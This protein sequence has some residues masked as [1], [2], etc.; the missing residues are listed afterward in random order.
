MTRLLRGEDASPPYAVAS[1]TGLGLQLA[2]LHP[3]AA[4]GKRLD[5]GLFAETI[6]RLRGTYDYIVIDTAS[7]LASAD[8]NSVS[9]CSDGV[10]MVARA[11]KSRKSSFKRAVDQL[12]PANVLGTVL[13]DT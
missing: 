4:A 2:A 12:R 11:G 10:I 6:D 5:R 13:I 8:A 9:Q 1:I 3:H 7:V